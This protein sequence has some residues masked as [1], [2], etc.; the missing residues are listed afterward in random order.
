M[1]TVLLASAAL[2][3]GTTLVFTQPPSARASGRISGAVVAAESGRAAGKSRVELIAD[4][5]KTV[6]TV[7][8]DASSQFEFSG[9]LSGRYR[10][11]AAKTGYV[12]AAFG[13]ARGGDSGTIIDLQP[14]GDVGSLRI[15]L[16][17]AAA[18]TGRIVTDQGE[19][20][21]QQ[22]VTA[23]RVAWVDGQRRLIP[24]PRTAA[25][26]DRGEY[27]L[28]G[29]A[30]GTYLVNV[31]RMPATMRGPSYE[32]VFQR[33]MYF[34]GT[35][36]QARARPL[37]L[38]HGEEL[39]NVDF[40]GLPI[41]A[42]PAVVSGDVADTAGEMVVGTV[43]A[44]PVDGGVVTT[45]GISHGRYSMA[46]EPGSYVLAVENRHARHETAAIP[47]T[48]AE[49]DRLALPVALRPGGRVEGKISCDDGSSV[50]L[51]GMQIRT[52]LPSADRAPAAPG[53][54]P[55]VVAGSGAFTLVGLAGVRQFVV[56]GI[57]EG[58][59]L[60]SILDAGRDV[61]DTSMFFDERVNLK[62]EVVLTRRLGTVTGR[63]DGAAVLVLPEDLSRL[64]NFR[65]WARLVRPDQARTYRAERLLPGRYVAAAVAD[66]D[67]TE[68]SRPEFVRRIHA[69]A[70]PFAVSPDAPVSLDLAMVP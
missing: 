66:V 48:V 11:V 10:L 13:A 29:L 33:G 46:V 42:P 15:A 36:N 69:Q 20:L 24:T 8:T 44:I 16:H 25:T 1:K 12:T 5:A 55:I 31:S 23:F 18:I 60:K 63:T 45:V 17:R 19:A 67:E 54:R 56:E 3:L 50:P 57:P 62:V 64:S 49:H 39:R 52:V 59:A 47:F 38:D 43:A 35:T 58:W 51:A 34:P 41:T 30:A 21:P 65:R 6:A 68:W 37:S 9:V 53:Q 2:L 4:S 32:V 26:D 70:T 27:R 14:G 40:F 28:G 22:L 7:F 61:S